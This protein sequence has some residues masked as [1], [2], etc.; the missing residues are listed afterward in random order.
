MHEN[1]SGGT[2]ARGLDRHLQSA[3][4]K[5]QKLTAAFGPHSCSKGAAQLVARPIENIACDGWMCTGMDRSG[6]LE[7]GECCFAAVGGLPT[8]PVIDGGR[9]YHVASQHGRNR[10]TEHEQSRNRHVLLQC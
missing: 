2:T 4:V 3:N 7:E 6:E 1:S 10:R 9:T 5:T 8:P